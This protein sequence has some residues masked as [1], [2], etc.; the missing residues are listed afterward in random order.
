[1]KLRLLIA[2]MVLTCVSSA[3]AQE[4]WKANAGLSGIFNSGNAINQTIGGNALVS[5]K[6]GMNQVSWNGNGAYGR[7]KDPATGAKTTN[8]ENWLNQIRYDRFLSETFSLY[9]LGHMYHNKPTGFDLTYGGSAGFS[10][11]LYKSDLSTFKYELGFDVTRQRFVTHVENNIYSVRAFLQYTHKFS[12]NTFFGQD[13]E[14]LFNVTDTQD[15]RLN[16]LTSLNLKL[17]EKVAFQVGY[18][19]RLDNQPV[20][21][22]KK[23]DTTTQL[24]L[25]INIL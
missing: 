9:S 7:A 6:E 23:V 15:Y 25:N 16:T 3:F 5:V 10:H 2:S 8:T 24:G 18:A 13:V 19:I 11:F 1:M 14:N 20:P 22:F 17:T 12:E 21:G 4:E